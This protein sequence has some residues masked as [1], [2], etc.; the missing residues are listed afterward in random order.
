[1]NCK[2]CKYFQE[3]GDFNGDCSNDHF[4]KGYTSIFVDYNHIAT[5]M[6]FKET[7]HPN[8]VIVEDDEGWGFSVGKDFGCIHFEQA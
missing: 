6:D 4:R 5:V 8:D 1:M 3:T 2:N 7:V